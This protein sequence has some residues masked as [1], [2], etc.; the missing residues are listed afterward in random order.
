MSEIGCD[1]DHFV[2]GLPAAFSTKG[3]KSWKDAVSQA[4]V[5]SA[6]PASN[7]IN[8]SLEF[9]VAP[10]PGY[11]LGPDIDNLCEPLLAV[12]VNQL[13]WF[14]R[15]RPNIMGLIARKRVATPTGCRVRVGGR[16][17]SWQCPGE[18]LLKAECSFP[19]PKSARDPD[20]ANWV[21]SN[22][23]RKARPGALLSVEL[24][25]SDSFNLGDISTGRL[26]NV[27]DCLHPVLGGKSGAPADDRIVELVA[28]KGVHGIVGV[29]HGPCRRILS[30]SKCPKWRQ[31]QAK[32]SPS[33]AGFRRGTRL[34]RSR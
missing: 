8:L 22:M 17:L 29:G 3:E 10:A 15:R 31:G 4:L 9:S 24:Q 7:A 11:P 16:E 30:A 25:F 23:A 18:E 20:W 12:V 33:Q 1:F 13:G 19:L 21:D 26:K 32:E 5:G 28:S 2:A 6:P 14:G 34:Q 27:I